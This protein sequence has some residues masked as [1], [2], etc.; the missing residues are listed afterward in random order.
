[1]F[2]HQGEAQTRKSRRGSTDSL[3]LEG[4]WNGVGWVLAPPHGTAAA[5]RTEH[6]RTTGQWSRLMHPQPFHHWHVVSGEL[7]IPPIA[8]TILD[9]TATPIPCCN[10]PSLCP[11]CNLRLHELA[12]GPCPSPTCLQPL[13][14]NL[15]GCVKRSQLLGH[16][17]GS[18]PAFPLPSVLPKE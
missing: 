17:T 4:F 15:R 8:T 11:C 9:A 12:P 18:E 10:C 3:P 2:Q 5:L 14:H 13:L 6:P 7:I 16:C 1:M